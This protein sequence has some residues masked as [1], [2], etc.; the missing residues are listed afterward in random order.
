MVKRFFLFAPSAVAALLLAAVLLAEGTDQDPGWSISPLARSVTIACLLA[1]VAAGL[2]PKRHDVRLHASITL[3]CFAVSAIGQ[4]R[5][6][7]AP[8]IVYE[9]GCLVLGLVVIAT[10]RAPHRWARRAAGQRHDPLHPRLQHGPLAQ[11]KGRAR[12][13]AVL[14]I[15]WAAVTAVLATQL[16]RASRVVERRVASYFDGYQAPDDAVGFA[17]I[18]QLGS[19]RGMFKSATVVMRIDGERVDYLRGAVLNDYNARAQRW[20]SPAAPHV[21]LPTT[22]RPEGAST[23]IR[24]ARSRTVKQRPDA[25]WFLPADACDLRAEPGRVSVDPSGIAYPARP[26]IANEISFHTG[27]SCGEGDAARRLAAPLQ[28]GPIELALTPKLWAKLEPLAADWTT[29]LTS[30]RAKLDAIALHLG[31]FGYSLEVTRDRKVDA[32]VDLLFLHREGH[33]ELFASAMALLA[34]TQGIPTR[35]VAGYRVTEVNPVTGLSIV[36]ER[37]AH[38]W[39]EAWVDGRWESWDPTPAVEVTSR[40]HA[41]GWDHTSEL[42]GW[43]WDRAVTTFWRV[44]LARFGFGATAFAVVLL[45]IRHFMQRG[46]KGGAGDL[47]VTARPLPAFEKLATALERAGWVRTA[48]EPLERFARRLDGAGEPWAGDVAA[49]LDRYA[50]LR[51][52]GVGEE[53]TVAQRLDEL[54]RKIRPLA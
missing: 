27:A 5:M 34:R 1:S 29:G 41:S 21:E 50:E 25:R 30:D 18:I 12:A 17:S 40:G 13:V 28:P 8:E 45:V 51:Y 7:P 24:M 42:L 52:G 46:A 23:R 2:V 49:A 53:R 48:S 6:N 31:S 26:A 38:S 35:I 39:V 43:L 3:A 22:A 47:L 15:C 32:V 4:S 20:I 14:A 36:R 33:C 9:V 37:N 44:G 11:P 10:L 16:P 19:T 54:A